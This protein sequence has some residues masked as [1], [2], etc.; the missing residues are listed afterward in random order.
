MGGNHDQF[1]ESMDVGLFGRLAGVPGGRWRGY[2]SGMRRIALVV[3]SQCAALPGLSFLPSGGPGP[4]VAPLGDEGSLVVRLR[5]LLVAGPGGFDPLAVEGVTAPGLLVNPTQAQAD[6]VL[7]AG[8]QAAHEQEAV[9]LVHFLGHGVGY[10]GGPGGVPARH[11]LHVWDTVAAPIDTEPESRGWDPYGLINRRREH[12][13]GM[14]GLVLVID[15]CHAAWAKPTVDTWGEVGRGLL[16]AWVA[17]S[18]DEQAFDACLTR[19]TVELLEHG[20]EA[21]RHPQ[22]VLVPEL[23]VAEL[24]AVAGNR[25]VNQRPSVGGYQSHNPVL[26]FGRNRRAEALGDELGLGP[27]TRGLMLR[28]TEDYVEMALTPVLAQVTGHRV[29]GLVGAAGTGKSTL[30][31]A[32]RNPPPGFAAG[33][34]GYVQAAA[35]A[36]TAGTLR[37]LGADLHPQLGRLPRFAAAAYRYRQQ[38]LS[39]WDTL[40]PWQ[41]QVT[42]PLALIDEPVRI[43]VDG[44]DQLDRGVNGPAI[45]RALTDLIQD[46]RLSHVSLVV[47]SRQAPELPG[48]LPVAVPAMEEDAATRYLTRRRV[49]PEH[50]YR[51]VRLAAGNWLVLKLLADLAGTHGGGVASDL[52]GA[53]ATMLTDAHTRQGYLAD[54]ALAVLAAA[55]S[56]PVLPFDL[57]NAAVAHLAGT[58][59]SRADLYRVLGDPG[60]YPLLDRSRPGEPN[61]HLGLFHQTLTDHILRQA[62]RAAEDVHAALVAAIDG[63]APAGRHRPRDYRSDPLLAY[64]FDAGPRHRIKAG[65]ASGAVVDLEAREDN[66]PRVNLNRW[67]SWLPEINSAL[68]THHPDTLSARAHL[69]AWIGAAGE[70]AAAR[71]LFADLLPDTVRMLGPNHPDTLFA[72]IGLVHWTGAAGEPAAARDLYFALVPDLERVLGPDHPDTLFARGHLARWTGDAAVARD[73]FTELLPDTERVLGPDHPDTLAAR[74]NLARWAGEAGNPAAARDLLAALLPDVERVIGRDDPDTLVVRGNLAVWTGVAGEPA[75][76]RDLLAA[77]LP[78]VERVIGPDHPDTLFAR[79]HLA[80]WIGEAGE[81]AAAR[82]LYTAV[83]PDIE[84]VLGPDHPH[85][86]FARGNLAVWTGVA[87]EPAAAR[88]RFAEL[89]PDM[90]RV[91]GPDHPDALFVRGNVAAWTGVAGEPAAARGLAGALLLDMERLLGPDHPHTLFARGHLAR[92]IGMDGGPAAARDLFAALLPDLERVLGPDHPDTLLARGNLA[93]WIGVAGDPAA[94]RDLTAAVLPDMER[95]LG[96][97]HPD[98]LAARNSLDHWTQAPRREIA[99][100]PPV[101]DPSRYDPSLVTHREPVRLL[102]RG[103]PPGGSPRPLWRWFHRRR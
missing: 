77:L 84:R 26:H 21:D 30:A 15:A 19:T 62:T 74:G 14:V 79:G 16:S 66:H 63:L 42:G 13:P 33:P 98:T 12:V 3:G 56:G 45:R 47:T 78:D 5:D 103:R 53:Y 6:A 7:R 95:V 10:R 76:A 22:G 28:L 102:M 27:E 51:L 37:D 58:P 81:P 87:G 39:K 25:C 41:R 90:E 65:Q 32:L 34:D 67:A 46:E 92:W 80:A 17:A 68:G 101:T 73:R 20:L 43:L 83:L 61:E 18:G 60:L 44:L 36:A 24:D 57:L 55:G 86:L 49:P 72:R 91:L 4:G 69:A 2:G 31:A 96:P 9:L 89:L 50:H 100:N 11:L 23:T 70:P 48:L 59:V 88:D 54:L 94:A 93:A 82:D 71:D 35:F 99:G 97:D 64:A 1:V 75:A 8:L 85:T 38:N 52:H 40:D 29:V